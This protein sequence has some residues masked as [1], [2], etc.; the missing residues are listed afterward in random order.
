MYSTR[1][2]GSNYD[3]EWETFQFFFSVAVIWPKYCRYGVKKLYN[4]SINRVFLDSQYIV[5]RFLL[6]Y[7]YIGY[8]MKY[9]FEFIMTF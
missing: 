6:N 4:Q 8:L 1:A 5:F 7:I 3:R 2:E 9:S